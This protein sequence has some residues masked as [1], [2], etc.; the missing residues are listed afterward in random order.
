MAHGPAPT[1]QHQAA[2]SC[3]TKSCVN[4]L[5]LSWKTP[6]ENNADKIADGSALFG[7]KNHQAKLTDGEVGTI[8]ALYAAGGV[9]QKQLADRFGVSH[10]QVS[11]I[12]RRERRVE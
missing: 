12:I 8:R 1:R 9:T 10:Q 5:H 6:P 7:E 4:P 11:K 2:H 3:R